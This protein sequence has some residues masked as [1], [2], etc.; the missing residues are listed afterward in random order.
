MMC[1]VLL[2]IGS[3]AM[4]VQCQCACVEMCVVLFSGRIHS[5]PVSTATPQHNS[6]AQ[7]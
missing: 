7:I 5:S 2:Q 3:R 6:V 1:E 4:Q